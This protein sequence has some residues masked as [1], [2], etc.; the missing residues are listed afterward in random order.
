MVPGDV[1]CAKGQRVNEKMVSYQNLSPVANLSMPVHLCFK[2]SLMITRTFV[3]YDQS[4]S[5]LRSGVLKL[6]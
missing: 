1:N 5:F 4:T 3:K 2:H 6:A